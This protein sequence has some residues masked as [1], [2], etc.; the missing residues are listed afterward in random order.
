MG[1]LALRWAFVE[2]ASTLFDG[3]RV[4][5]GILKDCVPYVISSRTEVFKRVL[6]GRVIKRVGANY[7]RHFRARMAISNDI[8]TR[9]LLPRFNQFLVRVR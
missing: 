8:Q 3:G 7:V 9:M 6:A 1:S 5:A 4:A 2:S